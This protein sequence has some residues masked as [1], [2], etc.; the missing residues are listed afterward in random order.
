MWDA[1][2]TYVPA[3]LRQQGHAAVLCDAL[4]STAAVH[5]ALV[6][7]SCS[8]IR[9]HY[10]PSR[11]D[12]LGL[13][14]PQPSFAQRPPARPTVESVALSTYPHRALLL[15]PATPLSPGHCP[16]PH[17]PILGRSHFPR[18][19]ASIA[20][21]RSFTRPTLPATLDLFQ[22]LAYHG[23][24]DAE[25][26]KHHRAGLRFLLE[27]LMED[28]DAEPFLTVVIPFA[29][30]QIEDLPL[31]FPTAAV[32]ILRSSS[33]AASA[34]VH[35]TK[36]EVAAILCC[37]LFS[38]HAESKSNRYPT[39]N[40]LDL[41]A[42]CGHMAA[43]H[44]R[45]SK[46]GDTFEP[47]THVAYNNYEKLR[48][49]FHYFATVALRSAEEMEPIVTFH[50]RSMGKTGEDVWVEALSSDAQ[51]PPFEMFD[52]GTIEDDQRSPPSIHLDF[53]NKVNT[54]GH[55]SRSL[56]LSTAAV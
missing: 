21:Y 1:Y 53:A 31:I 22:Q 16:L 30:R 40:F 42:S 24:Q 49:L 44:V 35:L 23:T 46:R 2:E 34:S 41:F 51:L 19:L 25:Q 14:Q 50:R 36:R 17:H 32:P 12:L 18:V 7:P 15:S 29:L 33:T 39:A 55:S 8:Y 56:R 3:G 26:L 43:A 11:P 52:T 38:M 9:E 6:I 5:G 4:F 13:L 45:A 27:Q 54:S 37:S 28:A 47:T 10:L 48:C 20:H